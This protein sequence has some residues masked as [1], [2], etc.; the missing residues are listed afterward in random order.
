[1]VF[2]DMFCFL[3]KQVTQAEMS[4]GNLAD[5]EGSGKDAPNRNSPGREPLA[6]IL[7]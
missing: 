4:G 1:M 7:R 2:I 3:S 5:V 6:L